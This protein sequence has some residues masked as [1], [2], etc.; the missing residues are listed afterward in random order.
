MHTAKPKL[1]TTNLEGTGRSVRPLDTPSRVT[2]T[3]VATAR[4]TLVFCAEFRAFEC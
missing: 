2:F 4:F 1:A 3:L